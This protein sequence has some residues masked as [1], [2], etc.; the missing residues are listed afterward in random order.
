M[1]DAGP[2]H[3]D[4]FAEMA[5][6]APL[7]ESIFEPEHATEPA[8]LNAIDEEKLLCPK[9]KHLWAMK[10]HAKVRNVRPDGTAFMAR[11]DYCMFPLTLHGT[12]L[13]SLEDKYVTQCSRF[14]AQEANDE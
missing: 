9:C 1:S 14:C 2:L 11:E 8:W 5:P 6:G 7:A 12:E 13:F 3:F 4:Q 10:K